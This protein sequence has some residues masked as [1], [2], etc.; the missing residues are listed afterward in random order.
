[1]S[2]TQLATF[3]E[4]AQ[5]ARDSLSRLEDV[6]ASLVAVAH[7]RPFEGS[8]AEAVARAHARR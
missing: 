7:G 3:N 5:R 4:D 2:D 1:M 6:P 8:P